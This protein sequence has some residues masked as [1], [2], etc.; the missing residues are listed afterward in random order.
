MIGRERAE[1]RAQCRAPKIGE[2]IGVQAHGKSERARSREELRRL[3][4]REGN[5][6]AERIHRIRETIC[7]NG[8]QHVPAGGLRC[9][10][11]C[12]PW[13]PGGEPALPERSSGYLSNIRARV[14]ARHAIARA[15]SQVRGHGERVISAAV[16][17]GI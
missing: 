9:K 4:W 12:R 3:F 11:P 10:R 2:L 15:A 14:S 6:L 16:L 13:L 5:M 8:W 7:R 17:S 1:A